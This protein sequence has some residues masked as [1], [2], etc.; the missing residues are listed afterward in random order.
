[1]TRIIIQDKV[2]QGN[3]VS[4]LKRTV[5]SK[6]KLAPFSNFMGAFHQIRFVYK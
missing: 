5:R 3:L 6:E 4:F 2:S 1:M